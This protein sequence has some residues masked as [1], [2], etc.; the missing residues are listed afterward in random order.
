MRISAEGI[1]RGNVVELDRDT[2][3]P[4]GACVHVTLESGELTLDQKRLLAD[5]LCGA[6]SEDAS[7]HAAFETIARIRRE[8]TPR[9]VNCDVAP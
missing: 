5:D 8:V 6:W 9:D 3:L 1:L 4:S 2:G 7:L